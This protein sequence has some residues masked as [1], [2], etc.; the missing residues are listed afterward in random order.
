MDEHAPREQRHTA[1]RIWDRIREER[2]EFG[3]AESAVRHRWEIRDPPPTKSRGGPVIDSTSGENEWL[4][5]THRSPEIF[6]KSNVCLKRLSKPMV[7]CAT[8]G[9]ILQK[10]CS[11]TFFAWQKKMGILPP[12]VFL[13]LAALGIID[14]GVDAYPYRSSLESPTA[15]CAN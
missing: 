12:L 1:H 10:A 14:L 7:W 11:A 13:R 8:P 15:N 5:E 6:Q 3:V 9:H 2:P 4:H